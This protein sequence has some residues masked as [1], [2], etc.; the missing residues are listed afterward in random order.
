VSIEAQVATPSPDHSLG[1]AFAWPFRDPEWFGKMVLMGLISLIPIVGWLQLLGWMLTALDHLRHGWQ[2]LPPAAFRYA[3]RGVNVFV[4]S[5]VWGLLVAIVIYGAMGL[6]I[7]GI[8][9]ATPHSSS[10]PAGETSQAAFPLLLFPLMFGLTAG[11]GLI[12]I[13]AYLFVPVI[14]LYADRGG[15]GGAFNV[16]GFVHAV[17]NSPKE[18]LAA[19]A[20]ALVSYIISSLGS[21]LCYVGILFTIPYSMAILA[22]VLRWYEV[23]ARPGTLP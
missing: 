14:I 3:T 17:R 13:A 7:F 4:A 18:S 12:F 11:F 22:G 23:N 1:D 19:G 16:R 6:V 9:A 15:L 10:T 20:L 5:L 8:L 21:Y 2:V